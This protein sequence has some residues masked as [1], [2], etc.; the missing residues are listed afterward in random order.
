MT[1]SI[2][3]DDD[4]VRMPGEPREETKSSHQTGNFYNK[5]QPRYGSRTRL[6]S[7]ADLFHATVPDG[8]KTAV[9]QR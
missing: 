1:M 5:N 9:R 3:S 6:K 4:L 8:V 2:P 7:D